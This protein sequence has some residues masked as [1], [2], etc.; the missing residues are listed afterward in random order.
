MHYS[1]FGTKM[2]G[3]LTKNRDVALGRLSFKKKKVV[4][5]H[6][7]GGLGS[8]QKFDIFTTFFLHALIHPNLQYNF[9][10]KGG[11]GTP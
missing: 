4:N 6:N 8:S 5:F 7:W 1:L 10:C 3:V 11:R 9:F 2:K